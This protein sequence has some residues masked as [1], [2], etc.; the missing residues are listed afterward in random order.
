MDHHDVLVV[1]SGNAGIS[2]AA[3]LLRD[4][5]TGVSVVAPDAVHRYRPLLNYVGGGEATMPQLER[6]TGELIPD[7]ATWVQDAVVGVDT[8][9]RTVTTESGRTLGWS[10]LVLCPGMVE[11]WDATPGLEAAYDTGWAGSTYVPR[12]APLVWDR[13]KDLRQGRVLFTL[14]PEPAPCTPTALKPL[15]MACEHWHREGVLR[16]LD[17][18]VVLP[19]TVV[20]GLPKADQELERAFASYGVTVVRE[21]QVV[22][23]DAAARSVTLVGPEGTTTLEDLAFAHVVPHYRAPEWVAE[24]GLATE[25]P[26]GLV[27]VDP[28][29]LRHRRHP[30][31]WALGDAA[32][33]QTLS[34]GGALRHQVKIL[35]KNLRAAREGGELTAYDGYTVMPVTVSRRRLLLAEV[36]RHGRPP[37]SARLTRLARPRRLTWV[38]DRYVLPQVYWHRLLKGKV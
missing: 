28:T 15:T 1:G 3:R 19:R 32:D 18:T 13:L 27:D 31:V 4:A 23:V 33:L 8:S 6:P 2:L 16:D 22:G 12:T 9:A 37:L 36:D 5:V 10:T 29:T 14:P 30:D 25:G 20:T 7:G 21:S 26:G 38:V 34:S 24:S 11:D 35:S 17:L